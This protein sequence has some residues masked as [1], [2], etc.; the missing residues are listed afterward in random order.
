MAVYY[1]VFTVAIWARPAA[2]G[3]EREERPARDPVA[4]RRST[5]A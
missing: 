1:L 5:T 3:R 2:P 4:D